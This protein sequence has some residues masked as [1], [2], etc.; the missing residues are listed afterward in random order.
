MSSSV[1]SRGGFFT[2][3]AFLAA[4]LRSILELRTDAA[5]GILDSPTR[6]SPRPR[7]KLRIIACD[8]PDKRIACQPAD[9]RASMQARGY[10]R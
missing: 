1:S 10:N 3:I 8:G 6:Q 2:A 4:M 9:S 7:A 5:S